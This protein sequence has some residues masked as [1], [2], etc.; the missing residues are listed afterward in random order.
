MQSPVPELRF[1]GLRPLGWLDPAWTA[2]EKSGETNRV[3]R[4]GASTKERRME[5]V[6]PTP[7]AA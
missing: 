7:I 1:I 4:Y 3:T 5:I 2:F 6:H